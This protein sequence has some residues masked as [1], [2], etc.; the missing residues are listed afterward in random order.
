MCT[1][2]VTLDAPSLAVT[3]AITG[4]WPWEAVAFTG[5]SALDLPSATRTDPG[6]SRVSRGTSAMRATVIPPIGDGP[7]NETVANPLET[8]G[9]GKVR[10]VNA[11]KLPGSSHVSFIRTGGGID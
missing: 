10:A 3:I 6:T 2:D 7:L 5:K 11:L 4:G 9:A 8:S 1:L